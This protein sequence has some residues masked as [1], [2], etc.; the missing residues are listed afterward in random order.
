MQREYN[1]QE[2]IKAIEE[3]S[4]EIKELIETGDTG[5]SDQ[6]NSTGDTQLKLDIASDII[7]ERIFK[8]LPT[9]KAIVSEEQENII[10]LNENGEYLIA[11]DP[12]DGSSLV[13]VNL[14]VGSIYG[15]YKNEFNAKNIVASV[16]VVFG[17]RVE[18]VVAI[19]DVKMYRLKHGKF[20]FIQNIVLKQKGNLK[21][22]GSTQSAWAPHHKQ[23]VDDIFNDGYRLRYSGGM[24]TDL[25]QI[26]L[27]GGGL[28]SYP[29]TTD[30]HKGKLRQLFEVFPFALAYEKAGGGAID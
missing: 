5:K 16:Y 14:S 29:G 30:R 11:Y 19:D 18:M 26:L 13:D 21:A 10:N 28:F 2:I 23:M 15:I 20:E 24:V 12:L 9:V 22:P 3:A 6:E 27:K 4:I 8:Q 1:I 7:I 17:P 25:H